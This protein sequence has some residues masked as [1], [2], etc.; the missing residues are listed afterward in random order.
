MSGKSFTEFVNDLKVSN[1]VNPSDLMWELNFS[2]YDKDGNFSGRKCNESENKEKCEELLTKCV[3]DG[4]CCDA[5]MSSTLFASSR[6]MDGQAAVKVLEKLGFRKQKRG[7]PYGTIHEMESVESWMKRGNKAPDCSPGP[8]SGGA[9]KAQKDEAGNMM[10]QL[11]QMTQA[12]QNALNNS[13]DV[14]EI[15]DPNVSQPQ[16][17]MAP[18]AVV[19]V[20]KNMVIDVNNNP[21]LLNPGLNIDKEGFAK[22]PESKLPKLGVYTLSG[23]YLGELAAM[24]NTF[25]LESRFIKGAEQA[26]GADFA[27]ALEKNSTQRAAA[28]ES[29]F[30][31][32]LKDLERQEREL[33]KGEEVAI[34][35][36]INSLKKTEQK[37]YVAVEYLRRF[38]EMVRNG[39]ITDADKGTY[40][41]IVD[42]KG[43]LEKKIGQKTLK[44]FG[45]L[46]DLGSVAIVPAVAS[47]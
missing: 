40:A 7:S 17:K 47:N 31:K 33:D 37:A 34:R 3:K 32:I 43:R 35:G 5:L 28:L 27:P 26:G 42:K 45:I 12:L 41:Q 23:G 44:L 11:D 20:L 36:Y 39:Q 19:E 10:N 24:E 4:K 8:I 30:D 22:K 25:N 21:I 1:E 18:T 13:P 38:A 16:K 29:A 9:T 14:P 15:S 46:A 6:D 2:K